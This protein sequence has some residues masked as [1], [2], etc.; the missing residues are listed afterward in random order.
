MP[1][2]AFYDS[3]K[4]FEVRV[5]AEPVFLLTWGGESPAVLVNGVEFD[6]SAVNRLIRSLRRARDQTYGS[7][8]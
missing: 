4:A 7:D 5:D 8:D 6:R 2:E 3:S 1:K